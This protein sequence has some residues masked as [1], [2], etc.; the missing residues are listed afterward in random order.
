MEVAKSQRAIGYLML[1]LAATFWAMTGVMGLAVKKAGVGP[2]EV[3]FWRALIGGGLFIAHALITSN[4]KVA[5]RDRMIFM[6]FGLPGVAILFYGFQLGVQEVG[7]A[8]ATMLQYTSTAWIVVWGV[9]FFKEQLTIWKVLA[10]AMAITG[11][12]VLCL[13]GGNI[14]TTITFAGVAGS[15]I[16]GICYSLHSPFGKKFMQ[17]YSPIAIYM[18]T[19]PVGALCMLPFV[20]FAEKTPEIWAWLV[21]LSI[22]TVWAAYWCYCEGVKRIEVSKVGVICSIEPVIAM[23]IGMTYFSESFTLM[24]GVGGLFIIAGV[25]LTLKK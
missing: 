7:M 1:F 9:V 6:A 2:M 17:N 21:G 14:S 19:M 25:F 11:A 8:M 20:T 12:I 13:A 15:L 4:Y 3:A 16:S 23:M 24:G 5:T 10:A 22:V 18:H